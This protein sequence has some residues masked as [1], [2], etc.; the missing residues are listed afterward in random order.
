M[1]HDRARHLFGA[2]WDDELTQAEREGLDAHFAG[3]PRCR[4]EY[5]QFTRA[6]EL[7]ASLPRVE[8]APDL[9]DRVLARTRRSAPVPDALAETPARWV[10]ATVAAVAAMVVIVA[11]IVVPRSPLRAP[12]VQAPSAAVVQLGGPKQPE[13]VQP[14][15]PERAPASRVPAGDVVFDPSKDVEFVLDPVTLHRGHATVSTGAHR[16]EKRGEEAVITF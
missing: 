11:L 9:L 1:N 12:A 6:L 16:A 5:D 8:A 14:A 3:C 15:A 10:P 2:C 13:R 4:A 7:T